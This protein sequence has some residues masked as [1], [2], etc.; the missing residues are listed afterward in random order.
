M[1]DLPVSRLTLFSSGVGFFEHLGSVVGTEEITLP[2]HINAVNDALKS[3]VINDPAGCPSVSYP[4]DE[5]H[6]KTLM[7]LS[8]DLNGSSLQNM[9]QNLKG[10]EIEVFAPDSIKGRI[11]FAERRT[12]DLNNA[13]I[14]KDFL[15]LFTENGIKTICID[16]ISNFIFTD[17]KVTEDLNRALDLAVKYRD[18][19]IRNLILKLAGDNERKVSFSYVIPAAV[20]KV[21]YRLN[22]ANEKPFLQGWAIVDNNSDIDWNN[23]EL[24]LVTGKPVSFIQDL[25]K[26]QNLSRPTIPLLT[27]G[28][29]D[30]KTYDSGSA[31]KQTAAE[32]KSSMRSMKKKTESEGISL[33]QDDV[34]LAFMGG[35]LKSPSAIAPHADEEDS[36]EPIMGGLAETAALRPAG[37]QFE[38]TIKKPVNL[39]RQQ[40][41]MLPLVEGDVKAEKLLVFSSEDKEENFVYNP[42]ICVELVNNTGIKLPSGPITVY[43]G[44]SYAGDALIKFFPENE[45][46]LIS[47]GD[48]LSVS[49]SYNLNVSE[50]VSL[51][52]IEK[53]F[54]SLKKKKI[55]E[56]IYTFRNAGK[57]AKKI[58]IE[59][60][61]TLNANLVRP[62][63]YSEKT[64]NLYR[65]SE[66][67]TPTGDLINISVIEEK[68]L[69]E[70]QQILKFRYEKLAGFLA[71]RDITQK[72]TKKVLQSS[73]KLNEK[74]LEAEN[75]LEELKKKRG[76]IIEKQERT[77]KNLEAAGNQSEQGK[78][79]LQ[80][81]ANE[82]KEI[83]SIDENIISAVSA[84]EA[85]KKDFENYLMGIKIK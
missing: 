43:D 18:E 62:K 24:S 57:E 72:N 38:F 39:M 50:K 60:P 6:N 63:E 32:F 69:Y 74:I 65:F 49:V 79:Y 8:I 68:I 42:A 10:T 37:D 19:R 70:E 71:N 16:E 21:S 48:E 13:L 33:S 22:L 11:I 75:K 54:M 23:I 31:K 56:T 83:D 81:L 55:Y 59:H 64:H 77:R 58:I 84:I 44:R 30:P 14:H 15:S 29:A 36:F 47:Y 2:F 20:W 51:V 25:Y 7:S 27:E 61:V 26:V 12:E 5:T 35:K 52:K 76:Q 4:S 85:A 45:K 78:D 1:S 41:S 73:F 9:L 28:I 53:G 40:S 82:D 80:R 67:L 66:I 17:P 46:R 34:D 3:L